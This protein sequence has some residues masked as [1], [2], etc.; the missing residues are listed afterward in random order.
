MT[1]NTDLVIN[2]DAE[3]DIQGILQYTLDTWG[4]DQVTAYWSVIWEGFQRIRAFPHIGRR[5]PKPD[6][7]ELIL[8]YHTIV[9]HYRDNTVT[10][11]R[12]LNP[13]RKR[14]GQ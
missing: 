1:S 6:E 11:L 7:R 9:Y 3:R 2:P 12:I 5:R 8:R 14:R 4:D 10:I 13:R